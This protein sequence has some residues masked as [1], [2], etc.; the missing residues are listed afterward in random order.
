MDGAEQLQ[1]AREIL[2]RQDLVG[3]E[4]LRLAAHEFWKAVFHLP[5]WPEPIQRQAQELYPYIVIRGSIDSTIAELD[6][7]TIEQ[8]RQKLTAFCDAVEESK[9]SP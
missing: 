8:A 5:S 6:E 1:M 7:A 9:R 4:S 2:A 3:R